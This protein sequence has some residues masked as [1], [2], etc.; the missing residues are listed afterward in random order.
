MAYGNMVEITGN[1]TR[2]PEIRFTQSGVALVQFGVAWNRKVDDTDEAHFFDVV[3]WREL[4]ENVAQSVTKGMRVV[5]AGRLQHRTWETDE[6]KRSKVE[7]VADEICPSLRWASADVTRNERSGGGSKGD[8]GPQPDAPKSGGQ[9]R[10][11]PA[12][13]TDTDAEPF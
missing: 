2:D 13:D 4:A 7:I 12:A 6:G 10:S 8:P 1:V 11:A 5:V 9:R 3:A